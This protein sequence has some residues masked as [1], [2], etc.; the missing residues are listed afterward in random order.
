MARKRS[1]LSGGHAWPEAEEKLL[2]SFV[3]EAE[4]SKKFQYKKDI[5]RHVHEKLVSLGYKRNYGSVFGKYYEVIR[6]QKA[7]EKSTSKVAE[8]ST[9]PKGRKQV[10]TVKMDPGPK[11]SK[12]ESVKTDENKDKAYV[13]VVSRACELEMS[14]HIGIVTGIV[15]DDAFQVTSVKTGGCK[16]LLDGVAVEGIN[17]ML[18]LDKQH[19]A[20]MISHIKHLY[21]QGQ[22]IRNKEGVISQ[23]L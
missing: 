11:D 6:R 16:S 14:S 17:N 9:V 21:R 7:A 1:N 18:D 2:M 12:V 8:K 4:E 22:M 13:R 20:D 19:F 3:E 15:F 5:F 23:V 10:K